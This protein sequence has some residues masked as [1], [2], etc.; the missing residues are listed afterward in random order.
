MDPSTAL[1]TPSVGN[2][3]AGK[4][5]PPPPPPRV[6][7]PTPKA[8]LVRKNS[9]IDAITAAKA[10]EP[11]SPSRSSSFS[12]DNRMTFV[13]SSSELH[14]QITKIRSNSISKESQEKL[15]ADVGENTATSEA[16][17]SSTNESPSSQ[18]ETLNSMSS[19]S[20]LSTSQTATAAA[21]VPPQIPQKPS[22]ERFQQFQPSVKA[23]VM[24]YATEGTISRSNSIVSIQGRPAHESKALA[25]LGE[26]PNSIPM[27]LEYVPV[28]DKFPQHRDKVAR[29]IFTTEQ[30]YVKNLIFLER[31]YIRPLEEIISPKEIFTIFSCIAQ[32]L[33]VNEELLKQLHGKIKDWSNETTLADA[34]QS[35]IPFLKMYTQYCVNFDDAVKKIAELEKQN[36]RFAQFLLDVKQH[37]AANGLDLR[38]FLIMP[39]QRI[40]RY[41][42]LLGDF[43]KH[44]K[45]DHPDYQAICQALEQVKIVASRVNEAIR[46]QENRNRILDIQNKLNG[47]VQLVD[48]HRRFVKEGTLI[49]SCR[50]E[51]KKR[52]FFLFNDLMLYAQ[53]QPDGRLKVSQKIDMNELSITDDASTD[54]Q[55]FHIRSAKKSFLVKADSETDK[56]AWM[57]AIN[58]TLGDFKK[59]LSSKKDDDVE[60]AP[61][62]KQDSTASSCT[63]CKIKFT[64][65]NRRHHC[66]KCG[67]VV[68]GACST[69]KLI[70]AGSQSRV[71]DNCYRSF[72]ANSAFSSQSSLGVASVSSVSS[73]SSPPSSIGA[74]E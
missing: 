35:L 19:S 43:I 32:I 61:V 38:S 12:S 39:V 71:C 51:D 52:T 18:A 65:T 63:F 28:A 17:N 74:A 6:N 59:S 62:W 31:E 7:K 2:S 4:S 30:S 16:A 54:Y 57:K 15:V 46:E 49:K 22:A 60:H 21:K 20:P 40:P 11:L 5:A 37:E 26:D 42:L 33:K 58:D 23:A 47:D 9:V 25:L 3:D 10:A 24:K 56:E 13:P 69:Q 53:R 29:E 14:Q 45:D 73:P 68:C 36:S 27:I 64:L 70:V 48:P 44:T 41:T 8:V 50:K 55:G 66:R 72:G 1:S 34:M 67:E